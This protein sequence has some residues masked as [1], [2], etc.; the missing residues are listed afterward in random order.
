MYLHGLASPTCHGDL[1]AV[2]HPDISTSAL[3]GP[4]TEGSLL[5]R[6]ILVTSH[7]RA[8]LCDFGLAKV[9]CDPDEP[10]GL[11]TS[12]SFRGTT[13]Y[14]SPELLEDTARHSLPADIWAW[15][16]VLIEVTWNQ[17]TKAIALTL[18]LMTRLL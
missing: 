18:P 1:K 10:S 8:M 11:T 15:G 3:A 4:P 13:R 17:S 14:M 9:L 5:Q 16:C 7:P 2:S 12:T 6:N